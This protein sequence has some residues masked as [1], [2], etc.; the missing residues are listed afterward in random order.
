MSGKKKVEH[1]GL[2]IVDTVKY[3]LRCIYFSSE[4]NLNA[5]IMI[6]KNRIKI[7]I[8]KDTEELKFEECNYQTL[9]N[10][11]FKFKNV[12]SEEPTDIYSKIFNNFWPIVPTRRAIIGFFHFSYGNFI[13]FYTKKYYGD[14]FE[15]FSYYL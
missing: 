9:E 5:M 12:W 1:N 8:E 10:A 3:V 14:F 11:F 7:R 13:Y 4:E 15:I 2:T 6:G